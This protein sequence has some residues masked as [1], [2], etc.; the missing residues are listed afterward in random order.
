MIKQV[1][2]RSLAAAAYLN[3]VCTTIRD[4]LKSGEMRK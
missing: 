1:Y 3:A 2:E 4:S